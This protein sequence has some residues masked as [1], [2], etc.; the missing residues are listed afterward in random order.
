M[1]TTLITLLLIS[2]LSLFADDLD[3]KLRSMLKQ[4]NIEAQNFKKDTDSSLYRLGEKL[5]S[6]NDLSGNRNISCQTCHHP[7]FGSSDKLPLP[8][9]EGGSGI[10]PRRTVDSGSIIP[11]N[12]PHLFNAALSGK[13]LMFWDGRVT[14]DPKTKVFQ[15]PEKGINGPSPKHPEICKPLTSALS[16][17][18]MFPPLSHDEMRGQ[19]GSNEI[20]DS[21][22]NIE[23]WKKLTQRITSKKEYEKLLVSAMPTVKLEKLTFGHLAEAIGHFQANKFAVNNTPFDK[24]LRGNNN[25]LTEN[26]KKGAVLFYSTA[27]CFMCHSGPNLTDGKFH[28][29]AF[30]QV[31]PGKDLNHDDKGLY[32]VTGV[33]FDKYKFKTPGLRNVA[34]TAP[35]GHSGSLKTLRKVVQHYE[36]PMRSNHHYDGGFRNL[37]YELPLEVNNMNKRLRLIDP[38]IGRMGIPINQEGMQNLVIFLEE[39]LTQTDF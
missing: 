16:A 14:Y 15:T 37:P 20:A 18:A 36:H 5:F 22:N 23:A 26:A 9:G 34:L 10:G 11:R 17:Q 38:Q 35:Y 8:I 6:D 2:P 3:E 25:A 29:V 4:Q 28:N 30:P 7:D 1:K 33:D 27:R 21:K 39:G 32:A 12:S 13:T 24:Y 19:K 31:G